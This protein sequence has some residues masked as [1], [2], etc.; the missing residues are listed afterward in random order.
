MWEQEKDAWKKRQASYDPEDKAI[1]DPI[2]AEAAATDNPNQNPS[3]NFNRS[4]YFEDF[5]E[6]CSFAYDVHST[7][8]PGPILTLCELILPSMHSLR[9]IRLIFCSYCNTYTV[10]TVIFLLILVNPPLFSWL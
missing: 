4:D 2:F 5:G 1:L 6:R 9:A 10:Y 8:F 7:R 3:Q